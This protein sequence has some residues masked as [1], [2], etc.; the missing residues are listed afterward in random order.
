MPLF[1]INFPYVFFFFCIHPEYSHLHGG[2]STLIT[3]FSVNRT[4]KLSSTTHIW[5]LISFE[6]PNLVDM[7]RAHQ[8]LREA[9]TDFFYDTWGGNAIFPS[10][11]FY[12]FAKQIIFSKVLLPHSVDRMDSACL[13]CSHVFFI[14]NAQSPVQE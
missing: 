10:I 5:P 4:Q 11:S 7:L 12:S 9:T 1:Y 3:Y 14:I 2:S 8:Q 13:M 6:Q